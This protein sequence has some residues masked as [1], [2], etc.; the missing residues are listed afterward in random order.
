MQ[1]GLSRIAADLRTGDVIRSQHLGA[2]V[3]Y[4][5]ARDIADIAVETLLNSQVAQLRR[6]TGLLGADRQLGT[7]P[8]NT[9]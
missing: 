9:D 6:R 8:A 7:A 3:S 5:G 1:V 2:G 4:I